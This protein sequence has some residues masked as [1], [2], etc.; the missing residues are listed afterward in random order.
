MH[1]TSL[2]LSEAQASR[3]V[4]ITAGLRH[5][6]NPWRLVSRTGSEGHRSR[7][8]VKTIVERIRKQEESL[9]SI[10]TFERSCESSAAAGSR[11]PQS[12]TSSRYMKQYLMTSK[13]TSM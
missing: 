6:A 4:V 13:R 5:V 3:K 12:K 7:T 11:T 9:V 1:S 2:A 10:G 8:F